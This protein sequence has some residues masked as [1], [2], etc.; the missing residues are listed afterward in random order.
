[1]RSSQ[2]LALDDQTQGV[3]NNGHLMIESLRV[4]NFRCYSNLKLTG[5]KRLNIV[6]GANS[7][8]KTTLLESLF[9]VAGASAANAAF[10]LRALRQLGGQLQVISDPSSYQGLWEDLFHWY[11]LDQI[12]SIEVSSLFRRGPL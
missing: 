5:L 9:M 6:V 11:K 1:M 8:G 2:S 12:I 4:A 7:S 3:E 10:Q